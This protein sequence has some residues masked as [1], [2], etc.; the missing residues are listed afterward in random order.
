MKEES[1]L[2]LFNRMGSQKA[3][4]NRL[5]RVILVLCLPTIAV[6]AVV[7]SNNRANPRPSYVVAV[8]EYQPTATSATPTLTIKQYVQARLP[9][10]FRPD[11]SK[12]SFGNSTYY[13]THRRYY[14]Q[15]DIGVGL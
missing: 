4:M 6:A 9:Q 2:L 15:A 3:M 11:M 14:K 8:E 7:I 10:N 13:R 1:T 12:G 5:F